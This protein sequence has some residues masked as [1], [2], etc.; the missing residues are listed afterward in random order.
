[1]TAETKTFRA[2]ALK[3]RVLRAGKWTLGSTVV[4]LVL[5]LATNVVLARLLFPDAFGLMSVVNMLITAMGLFSD[6]GIARSVIQSRS[7]AS[8]ELLDTAWT[9]QV[10]RGFG[11]GFGCI[12]L[13]MLDLLAIH[14]ALFKP[15]TVYADP[16][17][18][19]IMIA[20]AITP[21]IQGFDS[22]KVIQAK[23]QMHLHTIAKIELAGQAASA[24]AMVV[25]GYAFHTVWTLVIGAIVAA[26]LRTWLGF[27]IL[28][29]H[30]SRLRLVKESM[31][32]LL[33]TGRWVFL[34]SILF[35]LALNSDKFVLAGLIDKR[36]Y[37]IYSIALLMANVLQGLAAK[38]CLTIV[39]P[40]LA[41]VNRERPRDLAKTLSKFQ[42]AYDGI[43]TLLAGVLITGAPAV[44]AVLY[45][46]RYQDAGWMLSIL[47][48]GVV[49][50][51][52][53]IVEECYQAV[54][55]PQLQT[56]ANLLRL[57]TLVFGVIVGL[58]FWGI[59]GAITAVALCQFSVWPLA[60]WFRLNRGVFNWRSEAVL[61]PALAVGLILGW[62]LSLVVAW[63]LPQ[64]FVA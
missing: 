60:I 53:Q 8:P 33:K 47:A 32:E 4:A 56:L 14:L 27:A 62:A 36:M 13:A 19:W 2:P 28:P 35:F 29:G 12:A 59:T 48:V 3:G 7:G 23:R 24:I 45:D 6:I 57:C 63:A 43:I 41:E 46:H 26:C 15:G 58:H 38:M 20:F 10:I 11:L 51:R 5:R 21:M 1:M 44:I 18:A 64:R 54:G 25:V 37:G 42:W 55:A 16:R 49:G 9:V 31:T 34:S 40:A 22:I 61:V 30:S 17:L 52:Y 39:Y 50:L